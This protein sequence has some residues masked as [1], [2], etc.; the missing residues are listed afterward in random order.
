MS[1]AVVTGTTTKPTETETTTTKLTELMETMPGTNTE[2]EA[3]T[4]LVTVTP[5]DNTLNSGKEI[6]G[7]TTVGHEYDFN[8]QEYQSKMTMCSDMKYV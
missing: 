7:L 1:M 3:T 4:S 2:L 8:R 5:M 6:N